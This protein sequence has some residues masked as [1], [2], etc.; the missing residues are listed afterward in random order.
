MNLP[1]ARREKARLFKKL[2]DRSRLF[3]LP[4]A[5]D[6]V[7]ARIF[8]E[9][10][11]PAIATTSAG[12]AYS[13]GYS[14]RER[15]PRAVMAAAVRR[16][17][18]A[19]KVP[20]SADVEAGYGGR[21]SDIVETVSAM[22]DAGAVGI[23]LEDATHESRRPLFAT[24]VQMDRI[25]AARET[26]HK[27]GLPFVINVSPPAPSRQAPGLLVPH[28]AVPPRP[29]P[30]SITFGLPHGW[31]KAPRAQSEETPRRHRSR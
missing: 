28:V 22:I 25:R 13:H 8:E 18:E 3:I 23:N 21:T 2:H 30:P 29:E 15:I 12:I 31:W 4:N 11:Y 9:A 27:A 26:A 24:S 14:D 1:P 20:V 7:S 5:W 10:G 6:V 17:A 19:V 16:I